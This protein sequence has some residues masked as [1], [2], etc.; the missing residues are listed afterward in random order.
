V[1]AHELAENRMATAAQPALLAVAEATG[2]VDR[3]E[4]L[5]AEAVLAQLRSVVVDLLMV[6]GM[7][8]L[9]STDALPPPR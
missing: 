1:V 5:A 3:S 9:E 7:D 4:V 6:T 8:Q 2:Q